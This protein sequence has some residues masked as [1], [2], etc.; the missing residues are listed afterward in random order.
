LQLVLGEKDVYKKIKKIAFCCNNSNN[1]I[2]GLCSNSL[3]RGARNFQ[4]KCVYRKRC[5]NGSVTY[6]IDGSTWTSTPSA[7]NVGGPLYARFELTSTS[8]SGSGTIT[9]QL[10]KDTSVFTNVGSP[11]ITTVTFTGSAQTIYASTDG[12]TTGNHNWG[13]DISSGG[14]YRVIATVATA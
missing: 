8:H 2:I 13:A 7:F 14:S 1:N 11:V 9:W 6:S 3:C 5:S 4:W 12:T 10:Q